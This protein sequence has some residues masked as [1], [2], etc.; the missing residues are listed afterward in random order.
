MASDSGWALASLSGEPADQRKAQVA[1]FPTADR[2][3]CAGLCAGL[4]G[5]GSNRRDSAPLA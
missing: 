5:S 3:Q 1:P 2:Y 4:A